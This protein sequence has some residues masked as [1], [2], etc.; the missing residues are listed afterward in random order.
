MS[1]PN[2][3]LQFIIDEED[4]WDDVLMT[5]LS[6]GLIQLEDYNIHYKR[7]CRTRPFSGHNLITDIMSGHPDRGYSH[8]RMTNNMFQ[9]LEQLL[10]SRGVISGTRNVTSTEQLAFFLYCVGHGVS[11]RVLSETFQ[12]SGETISRYF[13]K[14]LKGICSLK[15]DFIVQPSADVGVHPRIRDNNLFYPYFMV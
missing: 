4:F 6:T 13:N 10:V 12:H 11:N 5:L 14:V 8:F 9:Q 3:L 15:H 7:P 2:Q 1:P